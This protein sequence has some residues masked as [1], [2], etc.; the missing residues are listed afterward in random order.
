MT[1]ELGGTETPP[2]TERPDE[3]TENLGQFSISQIL[4]KP[5][6]GVEPVDPVALKRIGEL[7]PTPKAPNPRR[8]E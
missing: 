1:V 5:D 8:F 2:K 4:P 6:L 3:F 7:H